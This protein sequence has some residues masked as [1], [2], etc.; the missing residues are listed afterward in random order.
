MAKHESFIENI[1]KEIV[2]KF[3]SAPPKLTILEGYL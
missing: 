1:R 3:G 2:S